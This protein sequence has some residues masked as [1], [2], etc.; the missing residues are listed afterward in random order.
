MAERRVVLVLLL[1][2]VVLAPAA[3]SAGGFQITKF[4]GDLGYPHSTNAVSVFWNPAAMAARPGTSIVLESTF[5]FRR[6]GYDRTVSDFP[7]EPGNLGR[8]RL[9]NVVAVPYFAAISDFGLDW[10]SFGIGT[11]VP[12]GTRSVWDDAHGTQRWSSINGYIY[13][14]YV[15]GGAAVRLPGRVCLGFT[16]SY[17]HTLIQTLRAG[18][19]TFEKLPDLAGDPSEPVRLAFLDDP[20]TES[21]LWVDVSDHGVAYSAGIYWEPVEGRVAIGLSYT[22]RLA[23][24]AT[25]KYRNAYYQPAADGSTYETRDV[26]LDNTFPDAV[27]FSFIVWPLPELGIR[28]GLSWVNWSVFHRQRLY[29]DKAFLGK[30]DVIMDFPRRYRDTCVL[31]GG[32]Q[33]RF[34]EWFTAY[35]GGGY[36]QSPIPPETLDATLFDLDKVG[37]S[38]G[39]VFDIGRYVVATVGY[40]HIFCL[41]ETVEESDHQPSAAGDYECDL[42]VLHTSVEVAF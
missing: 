29:V 30:R 5:I 14:I 32:L 1:A 39:G 15:T 41:P 33:Y 28:L 22:S 7:N 6:I 36:D 38:F 11:Y 42:D 4:G 34:L 9:D 21:R 18:S 19:M 40:N 27:H 37:L 31:R 13:S 16:V 25:G 3:V 20:H 8:A 24:S 17:A 12:F 26:R 23:V 2:A 35:V 10:L